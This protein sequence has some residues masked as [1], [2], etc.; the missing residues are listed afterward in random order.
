ML[1]NWENPRDAL[2]KEIANLC[3]ELEEH[4]CR[5]AQLNSMLFGPPVDYS[6]HWHLSKSEDCILSLLMTG[7]LT[8]RD[9]IMDLLYAGQAEPPLDKVLDVFI[10]R[11][12]DKL[13]PDGIEIKTIWGKGFR[14]DDNAIEQVKVLCLPNTK[15]APR[16]RRNKSAFDRAFGPGGS[17]MTLDSIADKWAAENNKATGGSVHMTAGSESGEGRLEKSEARARHAKHEKPQKV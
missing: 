12:R 7:R 11:L 17:G 16:V 1:P 4:K 15:A 2:H 5:I 9:L 13:R 3:R 10:M 8:S 14:M 6:N